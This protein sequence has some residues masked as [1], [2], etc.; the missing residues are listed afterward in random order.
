MLGDI[1]KVHILS[2]SLAYSKVL[3]LGLLPARPWGL[4]YKL[5]EVGN[6][7]PHSCSLFSLTD[8]VGPQAGQPWCNLCGWLGSK[9]QLT[10]PKQVTVAPPCLFHNTVSLFPIFLWVPAGSPSRGGHVTV[11]VF[12]MH[13]PSLPTPFTL[14]LR[15]FLSSWPF[16]LYFIP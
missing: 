9:N 14:F 2:V 8:S 7:T 6:Y 12:E 5:Q 4:V 16:Q 1:F 15:Q 3:F 11:Y 10:N 13:R